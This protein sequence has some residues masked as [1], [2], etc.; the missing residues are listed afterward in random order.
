LRPLALS[1][2]SSV[3]QPSIPTLTALGLDLEITNWRAVVAAPGVSDA[4]RDALVTRLERVAT[5]DTWRALLARHG[6]DDLWLA[7]PAFRQFL[8][9][10]QQRVNEALSRLSD[11]GQ[12]S[13]Q[14]NSTRWLTPA[15]APVA[16]VIGAAALMAV[17]IAR[18]RPETRVR[19]RVWWL[20]AA[21]GA[22]AVALP[23][24]GFIPAS[25]LLFA[26]AARLFGSRNP[27]RDLAIGGA[28]AVLL[29][30]GFTAGLGLALP[31]D[32][33][34]RWIAGREAFHPGLLGA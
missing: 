16:S 32:P 9:A 19:A 11:G 4:D 5:S 13:R 23:L 24:V 22:H 7:G 31:A 28:A 3:A 18:R 25:T 27:A 10:E 1:A 14:A 30:I 15:T 20:V 26:S 8:L 21:L 6:W 2:A 12:G 29:Y 34:T 17:V 33:I